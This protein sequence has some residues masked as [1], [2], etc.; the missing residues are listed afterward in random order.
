M[1]GD[2]FAEL[3]DDPVGGHEDRGC[4]SRELRIEETV[5]GD[6]DVA[7][8]VGFA[9]VQEKHVRPDRR[10]GRQLFAGE[11]AGEPPERGSRH[12][13]HVHPGTAHRRHERNPPGRGLDPG[14]EHG[15]GPLDDRQPLGLPCPAKVRRQAKRVETDVGE[16]QLLDRARA[17]HQ[18]YIGTTEENRQPHRCPPQRERRD[19]RHRLAQHSPAPEGDQ[20]VR[21]DGGCHLAE[22]DNLVHRASDS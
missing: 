4:R 9:C 5:T 2:G 21:L 6:A 16:L 7:F 12:V 19:G 13:H 17:Q 20:G 1:L 8:A 11:R 18:V 10:N 15:F 14:D 22:R 3:V